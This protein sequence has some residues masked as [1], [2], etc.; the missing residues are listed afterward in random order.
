MSR[1][2]IVAGGVSTGKSRSIT[3]LPADQ[4]LLI[5]VLNKPLPIK[6]SDKLYTTAQGNLLVATKH[7]TIVA[8]IANVNPKIK[9]IV[10]DDAGFIMQEEFFERSRETGY[11]KF[12]DIGL[13]MK[14]IITA[15]RNARADLRIALLFHEEDDSSDQIKVGK[16][17]KLIGQ[18]L[19]DKY[20][21]LATV[22]VCLF[23]DCQFATGGKRE[24]TF[25]TNRLL[26]NGILVPAKSPEGMFATD[27]IPNDLN[28]V[29]E[30]MDAYYKE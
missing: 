25:I 22:S 18:L 3:T 10:I 7:D 4:T 5:N 19:D 27:R 14:Q 2:L 15:C 9:N 13:H 12:S 26:V 21:P 1:T 8:A 20:N 30:T 16:K 24:Y 6:G 17:L 28:L 11:Q 29:F 23:T